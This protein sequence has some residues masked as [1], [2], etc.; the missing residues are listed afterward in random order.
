[1]R[2]LTFLLL[3]VLWFAGA[4]AM[5]NVHDSTMAAAMFLAH[6]YALIVGMSEERKL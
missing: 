6:A 1:M 3:G 5:L 4:L 2:K